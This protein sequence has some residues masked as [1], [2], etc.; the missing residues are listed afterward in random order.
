MR[1]FIRRKFK[2]RYITIAIENMMSSHRVT[3]DNK[4]QFKD[5]LVFVDDQIATNVFNSMGYVTGFEFSSDKKTHALRFLV[6]SYAGDRKNGKY[7]FI[8]CKIND[9]EVTDYATHVSVCDLK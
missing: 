9:F 5:L 2:A 3:L 4:K 8:S 7:K 6:G 1:F